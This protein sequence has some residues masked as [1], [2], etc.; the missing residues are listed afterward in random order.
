MPSLKE[1]F[2]YFSK[3]QPSNFL[4]ESDFDWTDEAGLNL[5]QALF[6]DTI[7]SQKLE[8]KGFL[9][10]GVFLRKD[11]SALTVSVIREQDHLIID[12]IKFAVSQPFIHRLKNVGEL[13]QAYDWI[14]W[15]ISRNYKINGGGEEADFSLPPFDRASGTINN[16]SI[17]FLTDWISSAYYVAVKFGGLDEL[18]RNHFYYCLG[19]A[20]SEADGPDAGSG[21]EALLFLINWAA[22]V[23]HETLPDLIASAES[24]LEMPLIT[25]EQKV[26][27]ASL[28]IGPGSKYATRP[29]E[30]VAAHFL[31]TY[32]GGFRDHER[33]QFL[34]VATT[35]HEKWLERKVEIIHEIQKFRAVVESSQGNRIRTD[36]VMEARI[37]LLYPL[38]LL[39]SK[40]ADLGA[41]IEVLSSWYGR[42]YDPE[43]AQQT[44][45]VMPNN[46]DG[47]AWVGPDTSWSPDDQ[48]VLSS[49]EQMLGVA[50]EAFNDYFRGPAGDR[51]PKINFRLRGA[52]A[53]ENGPALEKQVLDHYKIEEASKVISKNANLKFLLPFPN[54]P[55]PLTPLVDRDL[56]QGLSQNISLSSRFA[57]PEV[58]RVLIWPGETHTTEVEVDA[59]SRLGMEVG[60]DV[61]VWAGP[62]GKKEFCE[63]WSS[64][65][66]ELLWITGHGNHDPNDVL[67]SGLV[68]ENYEVFNIE[69]FSCLPKPERSRAI[70]ANI[71]SGGAARMIG[72]IGSTGVASAITADV[73]ATVTHNWPI[74]TYAA[75]AFGVVYFS[76]IRDRG[77][78]GG[79]SASREILSS[80]EKIVAHLGAYIGDHEVVRIL[81]SDHAKPRLESILSWGAATL[82]C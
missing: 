70:V 57:A 33:L 23:D 75:L 81:G 21:I 25:D 17:Q 50:S 12:A 24:W 65:D 18:A 64:W 79:L 19:H 52:P 53:P 31:A 35:C 48:D 47:V 74:D 58:K 71:C 44:L 38:L 9:E 69:D 40:D 76:C 46:G 72:G 51:N 49:L 22:H 28:L 80:Q 16:F 77:L 4:W 14:L 78:V 1:M 37:T 60:I 41:V 2:Q 6:Q 61:Q 63:F 54:H 27:F 30:E 26:R 13:A 39:L 55:V 7:L 68:L 10:R 67:E 32:P 59:I 8:Q 11:L 15:S 34:N 43:M 29:P 5:A 42:P 3:V 20:I 56:I 45:L 66:Y 82:Y 36:I 73:Q 62:T